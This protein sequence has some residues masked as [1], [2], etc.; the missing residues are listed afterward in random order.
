MNKKDEKL[1]WKNPTTTREIKILSPKEKKNK[2]AK[3][4]LNK[5]KTDKPKNKNYIELTLNNSEF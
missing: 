4:H 3:E 5:L 2:W 1:N